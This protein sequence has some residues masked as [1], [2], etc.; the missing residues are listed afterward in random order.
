MIVQQPVV[1][2][3]QP[4][5]VYDYSQPINTLSAPPQ[6]SVAD[7]GVAT[8]DQARQAFKAGDY[9]TALSQTDAALVSMPNDPTLHEFRALVL[10]AQG[11][12]DAAAATLYP[13]LN[14]GPGWDWTTLVGLYPSVD[15]YTAQLR[16]LEDDSRANPNKASD[17]FVLAYNY[18]TEGFP[19]NAAVELR[20]VT[21]LQP[22]DTL[23]ARLLAQI[24]KPATPP[25]GGPGDNPPPDPVV[26]AAA[27]AARLPRPRRGK[28]GSLVGSWSGRGKPNP[29]TTITLSVAADGN[30]EWNVANKDGPRKLNGGSTYGSDVLTLAPA[31]G[32]PLVGRVNW[33]DASHF[34]FQAAGGGAGDPGLAFT[35]T[36]G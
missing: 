32:D 30:F 23:S 10:F 35:K 26:A 18:L 2:Q 20:Q 27:A 11:Q 19:D 16:A 34:N 8:F 3:A 36:D 17:H 31:T 25:A 13:V 9:A 5:V 33:T 15:T 24:S 29:D 22:K 4:V 14:A 1:A 21:L 12:Y 7:A 6:Q 28:C